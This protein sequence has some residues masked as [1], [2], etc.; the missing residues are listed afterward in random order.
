MA[1]QIKKKYIENDAIDGL[2]V[3]LQSDQT[4]RRLLEDGSTQD[5]IAYLEGLVSSEET[6]ALAAESGLDTRITALASQVDDDLQDAISQ[7]QAEITQE[8]SDRASGDTNLQ[9]QITSIQGAGDTLFE[10]DASVYAD[11]TAGIEDPNGRDGW[12]YKSAGSPDK[13]NWYFFDGQQTQVTVGQLESLYTVATVDSSSTDTFHLAYYTIPLGDGNDAGS[14]YRSRQVFV[15]VEPF[16]RGEKA[17]F[18]VKNQPDASVYP[19]LPRVEMRPTTVAGSSV[20]LNADSELLLTTVFGTN[21][22][23]DANTVELVANKLGIE[24]SVYN[25]EYTLEIRGEF[26]LSGIKE[27]LLEEAISR[28]Q[29]DANLQDQI[30]NMLSNV[31]PAAIDSFTEVITAFENADS[32]LNNAITSLANSASTDLSNEES[33]RISADNTLQSN[34]DS[35]ESARI[36][37]DAQ[38][39]V[40]A[41]GYTDA[42]IA[43]IPE[44]DL[45]EIE[46]DILALQSADTAL[47]GKIETEKAR[48]DA[49][50]NASEADKDSFV[51]IV[52]LINSVDT[53]NDQ[54]FA[55]Y[56]ASNNTALAQETSDRQAGDDAIKGDLSDANYRTIEQLDDA[57]AL[58]TGVIGTPE[59]EKFTLSAA[60]VANGY[61]DLA[62]DVDSS[63]HKRMQVF[64]GR[65]AMHLD[66]D[67]TLSSVGGLTR[68]T[69]A[70]SMASGGVEALAEGDVVYVR[71]VY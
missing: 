31:D 50:L 1:T 20:G 24:S 44:V 38:V 2:K 39:L 49:I 18:W 68:V 69:F 59:I 32:N 47:D 54:A 71:Y 70:G 28:E 40:D 15:P 16:Q 43:A 4:L 57:I 19:N 10:D 29:A 35:E 9:N 65:L 58:T 8:A 14:W 37:A 11:A 33:A 3:L 12:Y 23:A 36:A 17:L 46:S 62:E 55:A 60:D 64:V 56:V 42:Q 52:T 53:E 41:K 45:S 34:I 7:L 13:V 25:K 21:S 5:V 48:V 66:D 22:A 27:S 51:E 26:T 67:F 30:N 61:I 6:R 63:K